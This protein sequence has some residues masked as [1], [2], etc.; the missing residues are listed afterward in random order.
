MAR[1]SSKELAVALLYPNVPYTTRH[2]LAQQVADARG[3]RQSP[4]IPATATSPMG[5]PD[6]LNL[7]SPLMGPGMGN[8]PAP[9]P[10]QQSPPLPPFEPPGTVS[11]RYM[12][13]MPPPDQMMPPVT[14]AASRPQ[15]APAP[16]PTTV[17]ATPPLT[18]TTTA[19][20]QG[21]YGPGPPPYDPYA[22]PRYL[23]EQWRGA[24]NNWQWPS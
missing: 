8:Q 18:P 20:P 22:D 2:A 24:F 12:P 13:P 10:P 5:T 21:N 6:P 17:A 15:L 14:V 7:A 3:P 9:P 4:V 11:N 16:A 19:S 1:P 23:P